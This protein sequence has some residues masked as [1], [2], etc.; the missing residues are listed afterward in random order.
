[1]PCP[2]YYLYK[3]FLKLLLMPKYYCD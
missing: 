3:Y 2:R 1:M